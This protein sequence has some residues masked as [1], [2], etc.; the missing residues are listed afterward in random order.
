MIL[1]GL[2]VIPLPYHPFSLKRGAFIPLTLLF[3]GAF[4]VNLSSP[5]WESTLYAYLVE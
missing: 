2:I 1:T 4:Q 3:V 5:T